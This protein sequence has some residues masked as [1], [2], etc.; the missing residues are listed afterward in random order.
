MAV[1]FSIIYILYRPTLFLVYNLLYYKRFVISIP[2]DALDAP[3]YN[4]L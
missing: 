3:F 2:M 4:L 1:A